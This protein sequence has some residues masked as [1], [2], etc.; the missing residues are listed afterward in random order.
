MQ[1]LRYARR[2]RNR[3]VFF[4]ALFFFT[5]EMGMIVFIMVYYL[6]SPIDGPI[7]YGTVVLKYCCSIALH[8]MQQPQILQTIKRL[9]YVLKHPESFE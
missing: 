5:V 6:T 1:Y 4:K 9:D 3:N 7:D 8:L 2:L